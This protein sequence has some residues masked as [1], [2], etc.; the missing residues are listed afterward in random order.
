MRPLFLVGVFAL[1]VG[2]SQAT[3]G[4]VVSTFDSSVD[5]WSN[6]A[7]THQA[8]GGNPGGYIHFVDADSSGNSI[9][10]PSKFLGDWS[11]YDG[12]SLSYDHRILEATNVNGFGD[13]QVEIAGPTDS[14][15]WSS[16]APPT[17]VTSWVS[18]MVPI[19]E[20]HWSVTG[21]WSTLLSDVTELR[22]RIE[23]VDDAGTDVEGIDNVRLMAVP[24]PGSA[25]G[26]VVGAMTLTTR[27]R[28][29][30]A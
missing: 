13:Y 24:E 27:R 14:A 6:A 25:V 22:I 26:I 11:I 23:H 1:F 9:V 8:I 12:G 30:A 2:V 5:G 28:R 29:V 3:L 4:N 20:N 21:D 18:L 15:L 10:A 7:I 17:G 19:Q 16:G